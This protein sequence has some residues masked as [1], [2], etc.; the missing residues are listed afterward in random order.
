MAYPRPQG[1]SFALESPVA[2]RRPWA[3]T[4]ETGFQTL[5]L[6]LGDC[7]AL[8]VS[9]SVHWG[10]RKLAVQGYKMI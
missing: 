7:D 2:R 6:L 8:E 9:L 4:E 3:V 5:S 1:R 10:I